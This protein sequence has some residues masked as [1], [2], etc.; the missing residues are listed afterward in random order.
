MAQGWSLL[1][2]GRLQ[3]KDA[4]VWER[5]CGHAGIETRPGTSK[6]GHD[7]LT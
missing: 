5:Q 4:G 3:G 2:L 7:E 1:A 6:G